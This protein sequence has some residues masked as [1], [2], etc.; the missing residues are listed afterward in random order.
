MKRTKHGL[1]YLYKALSNELFTD[2]PNV[3]IDGISSW[4]PVQRGALYK[5]LLIRYHRNKRC[6]ELRAEYR[7]TYVAPAD[8]DEQHELAIAEAE[9][10]AAFY[11][12]RMEAIAAALDAGPHTGPHPVPHTGPRTDTPEVTDRKGSAGQRKKK[13]KGKRGGVDRSRDLPSLIAEDV[14]DDPGFWSTVKAEA[15]GH[16]TE[17]ALALY[18][19]L[20]RDIIQAAKTRVKS[21]PGVRVVH[22]LAKYVLSCFGSRTACGFS[23]QGP[24][25]E[26][27][28]AALHRVKNCQAKEI[29]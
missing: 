15:Y 27:T 18:N 14:A 24:W 22:T 17:D 3:D 4:E 19:G 6:A 8:Q 1:W 28:T 21:E 16:A 25:T 12:Q 26:W 7:D 2:L 13:K 10:R 9:R 23:D 5:D 11:L 20:L 29:R